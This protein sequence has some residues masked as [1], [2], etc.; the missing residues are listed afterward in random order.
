MSADSIALL[1]MIS[2]LA[3]VFG[4]VL[5]RQGLRIAAIEEAEKRRALIEDLERARRD[6][7]NRPAGSYPPFIH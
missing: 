1:A 4:A 5:R 7:S 3:L 6:A 2:A